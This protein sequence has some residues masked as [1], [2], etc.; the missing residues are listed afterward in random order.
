MHCR[1]HR[2]ERLRWF[3]DG[4]EWT[5]ARRYSDFEHLRKN[6]IKADCNVKQFDALPVGGG[7]WPKKRMSGVSWDEFLD[8]RRAG[9]ESWLRAVVDLFPGSES[10]EFPRYR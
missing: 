4:S 5:A 9:L 3:A 7:G 8:H 1:Q 2:C 6:L 10:A